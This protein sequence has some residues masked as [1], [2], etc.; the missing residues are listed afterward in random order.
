MKILF[1]AYPYLNLYKEIEAELERQGHQVT[2]IEDKFLRFDPFLLKDP[3]SSVKKIVFRFHDIYTRY[4]K[5]KI[6]ENKD[7]SDS[8]DLLLVLSGV[9]VGE[10]LIR[11]LEKRNPN[12]RKILYTWDSCNHYHFDRLLSL[13]DRCYTFDLLDSQQDSRWHLLPI[14]HTISKADQSTKVYDLFS[15]GGNHSGRYTFFKRIIPQ[16]QKQ[17]LRY[18]I[19]IVEL[20]D[21][22]PFTHRLRYILFQRFS[23]IRH[24]VD[25]D[26]TDMIIGDGK[27]GLK[28]DKVVNPVDYENLS[29]KSRCVIDTQREGQSGLTARFIWALA[30][31][32]K[33]ITTNQYALEYD[34]VN[35][36]QVC[37]VERNNPT[38]PFEFAKLPLN[39][40][41]KTDVTFLRIDNWVKALL[42]D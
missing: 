27:F 14:Y 18:Y 9:S 36:K 39:D 16:L 40:S 5:N 6:R 35:P 42:S 34:F 30:N 3:Y 33:I 12:I 21:S 38:F 22:I 1:I 26:E 31:G 17:N 41:G 4:W 2:Y 15:I 28:S 11:Y 7:L 10:Y 24:E 32:M 19:K 25:I 13:F 8:Y 37:V 29:K 23:P 20:R